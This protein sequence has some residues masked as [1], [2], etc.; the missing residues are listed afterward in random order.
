M[1]GVIGM[2]CRR[3]NKDMGVIASRLLRSLEYRGYDSTGVAC[4]DDQGRIF[5]RKDVGAPSA[6]VKTLGIED[7]EGRIICGQVRWATFGAVTRENSQPHEVRCK[8]HIYGAHNGNVTNT[9]EVKDFLV[10]RGH[11]V[12]SDN[13]GEMLVHAIEHHFA[14]E[15]GRHESAR[16]ADPLTRRECMRAAI[17]EASRFLEGSYAAVIVDPAT[18][19]SWGIKS[20]SSL[21]AGVGAYEGNEFVLVS[22]D[23][24]AVLNFTKNLIQLYEDEFVEYNDSEFAVFS[25]REHKVRTRQTGAVK[26]YA[27]GE[28]I[29][30]PVTRSKLRV[31]DTGLRKPFEYYMHQEIYASVDGTYKL[32]GL[33]EG[34]TPFN[35]ELLRVACGAGIDGLHEAAARIASAQEFKESMKEFAAFRDSQIFEKLREAVNQAL[36]AFKQD[37]FRK[38]FIAREFVSKHAPV[39][40]DLAEEL[41]SPDMKYRNMLAAKILDAAA[42]RAEAAKFLKHAEDFTGAVLGAWRERA[43][44]YTISC[45]TS[46]HASKTASLFFNEIAGIDI[47]PLL[48]GNFRGQYSKSL[49]KGDVLVGISQSGET[50]DLIDIFNDVERLGLGIRKIAVVNNENSTLGQEKSDFY[51]PIMCGPEISVPATKSYMSQVML[52]YHLA[53]MAA[54][55]RDLPGA[56][57][58]RESAA[59]IPAL[60]AGTLRTT[61]EKIDKLAELLFLRPSMHILATRISSVAEEGALKIRETVLNHT[62]GIEASEFKHGP[63]TILGINSIAG[64]EEM[65]SLLKSSAAVVSETLGGSGSVERSQVAKLLADVAAYEFHKSKPFNLDPQTEK[66]FFGALEKHHPVASSLGSSYP[67]LY[68]TGPEER[69]VRLTISQ[70][71]THKIRGASTFVIAEQN[72]SLER[73]AAEVP[74]ASS[75]YRSFYVPLPRTDDTLLCTFSAMAALQLLALKMSI[76]KMRYLD[77]IGVPMHGVHPDVPK[78]VSKSITVD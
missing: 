31:E 27:A 64:L 14:L 36:P 8:T 37:V 44:I 63:N 69:D 59:R 29:E 19:W 70:I 78:N 45:G 21:Y 68:V 10:R 60:I 61:E 11:T 24:T 12:V 73:N 56:R 50:K 16:Q 49:R 62:Q 54:E 35:K 76:K 25:L 18:G 23:L 42:G 57:A 66:A 17:L 77:R 3:H 55:K 46:F 7:L 4:Q 15:L 6:L 48:P 72:A 13:D 40:L 71:N 30:A 51:L 67:L 58:R 2:V 22:S 39:L 32:S 26:V 38:E 52:F 9:V 20:G 75:G 41:K 43:R 65:E 34:G 53:I 5:L 47:I 33:F 74:A 28:R 1:C